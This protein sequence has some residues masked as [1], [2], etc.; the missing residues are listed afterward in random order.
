MCSNLSDEAKPVASEPA[1]AAEYPQDTV[2]QDLEHTEPTAE[3]GD[4]Q[5]EGKATGPYSPI[6]VCS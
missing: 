1:A 6:P 3:E 5:A 4:T 2:D